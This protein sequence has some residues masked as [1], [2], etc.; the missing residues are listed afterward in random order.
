MAEVGRKT[1]TQGTSEINTAQV[2]LATGTAQ[3]IAAARQG[4]RAVLIQNT[5][6]SLPAYIGTSTIS[7]TTGFY[8]GPSSAVSVPTTAAIYG[9]VSDVAGAVV[10]YIE[11]F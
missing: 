4:R 2:T 7:K 6:T 11:V 1:R 9:T 8:V 10:A 3:A 5:S